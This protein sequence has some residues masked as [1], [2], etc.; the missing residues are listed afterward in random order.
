MFR[1]DHN[2]SVLGSVSTSSFEITLSGGAGSGAAGSER[3][4][5]W[6]CATAEEATRSIEKN[7][8]IMDNQYG[9]AIGAGF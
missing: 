5:V 2:D 9:P 8:E 6:F 1:K 7:T 3:V 4:E